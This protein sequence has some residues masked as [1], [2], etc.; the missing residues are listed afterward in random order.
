MLKY[1]A[2]IDGLR[3]FAVL[4]VLFF[5]LDFALFKGGFVGVDV[6][7]TISGFL[8]TGIVLKES[9]GGAFSFSRFYARRATRLI[10]A[11]L[12]IIIFSLTAAWFLLPPIAFGEFQES[13]I[14]SMFFS[15][16]FYF[17]FTQGGYF[18]SAADSIPLLHTWSL[19]VEEQFYL[20]MPLTVVLW[21]KIKSQKLQYFTL[22]I[23]F[24]LALFVSY[25]LTHI[26][27]QAAYFLVVS[28]IH[29]FLIGSIL[30]V[31]IF[32]QASIIKLSIAA[33][34]VLF[35][36]SISLL[37][38]TAITF[39]EASQFPGVLA[40]IPCTATAGIILAGVNGRCIS[41][42]ILGNKL[43]VFIGLLSYSLYLWHWPLIT[44]AKIYGFSLDVKNQL[45]L[46]VL[47]FVFAY[48][49]WRFIE[50]T[51]RYSNWAKQHKVALSFYVLPAIA[52]LSV[53]FVS[54]A[55]Q[56]FPVRFEPQVVLAEAALNSKPELG[57]ETCHTNNIK[58]DD[59]ERC[60]LGSKKENAIK[61]I[62]WGDSHANHFS[63]FADVMGVALGLNILEISRGN[64]PPLLGLYINA[65]GAKS[66][67]IKRN[68]KVISY[69][70]DNK[71]QTV[72]L[73]AAWGGYL[74]EDLLVKEN[75][76]SKLDIV[77]KS[78]RNTLD[79][80]L[81]HDINP[82]V[83]E[84]LPR[85]KMDLSACYLN[86]LLNH[87]MN[88]LSECKVSPLEKTFP[89]LVA[90]FNNLHI[91]YN[92]KVDFISPESLFC[93]KGE[94]P[95][96]IEGV[97]IYRDSNHLNLQGSIILGEKYISSLGL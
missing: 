64:C 34:N 18:S 32:R 51:V 13:A 97:P 49:S 89:K 75:N 3:A 26:Y 47:S 96:Y 63:G 35:V 44:F 93:K 2:D 23:I 67:C 94:C 5:H 86:K 50:K 36:V 74:L 81:A 46:L 29:E 19:S 60:F 11:Y 42:T 69:I 84:M 53:F 70:I 83:I 28:R 40:V 6:F 27:Q 57:R 66:E 41:H 80:L 20:L 24:I 54:K 87:Q 82:I 16:N 61:A 58:I 72:I 25:F 71:P 62:L 90:V 30:A 10:P 73:A 43:L 48:F 17:L 91:D 37:F 15:S 95:T 1:R 92:N 59:S 78:L 79:I 45:L 85:Q 8:I 68:D 38:Y 65:Q 14:S 9:V 39:D 21:L 33:A 4:V 88:T 31:L 12:V 55:N 22:L 56:F 76:K 77:I 52:L 7:F